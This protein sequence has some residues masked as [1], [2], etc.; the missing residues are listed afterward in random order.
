VYRARI[1]GDASKRR[2]S[3]IKAYFGS[4]VASLT[5]NQ[6][7]KMKVARLFMFSFIALNA[8][9]AYA[10]P[11]TIVYQL[12]EPNETITDSHVINKMTRLD[13]LNNPDFFFTKN[14]YGYNGYSLIKKIKSTW[15]TYELPME[16]PKT[17]VSKVYRL[18][19][20]IVAVEIAT[21]YHG[22]FDGGYSETIFINT[23]KLYFF[24]FVSYYSEQHY[25]YETGEPKILLECASTFS[26]AGDVFSITGTHPDRPERD[27]CLES[28]DY[29]MGDTSMVQTKFLATVTDRL[30]PIRCLDK[31]CTGID[32]ITLQ[33][34]LPDAYFKQVP[35]YEY[36]FDSEE[37]GME[38]SQDGKVLFFA[39]VPMGQ[40][41]ALCAVS[42][43][44]VIM[45]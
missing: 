32:T 31:I 35:L 16:G 3:L 38:V 18:S 28:A 14:A 29:L 13:S 8:L 42:P 20:D 11:N 45:A 15:Y 4:I 23:N 21:T 27:Y 26:I 19:D 2:V 9:S 22:M 12:L 34:K 30:Y 44:Y 40:V 39:P 6:K 43:Q 36:G 25:N 7:K 33:R 17:V 5:I 10:Q 41:T 37:L 24:D 1:E